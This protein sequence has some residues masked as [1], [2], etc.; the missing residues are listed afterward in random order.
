LIQTNFVSNSARKR[1][2]FFHFG[3]SSWSKHFGVEK[4]SKYP[5][6]SLGC[7][8]GP[9]ERVGFRIELMESWDQKTEVL[10]FEILT[11]GRISPR[12]ALHEA[13][14]GLV[15]KFSAIAN[16]TLPSSPTQYYIKT[17][18]FR[19]KFSS[20]SEF[21]EIYNQRI[22]GESFFHRLLNAGLSHYQ[23]PFG[24][25]LRNL[26][27][28]KER[29]REFQNLGFQTLGQLLERLTSDF[30]S[31]PYCLEKKRHQA[32]RSFGISYYSGSL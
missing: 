15:Y 7:P 6:L 19:K 13:A 30:Y 17:K 20:C 14:L 22:F 10:I 25:E 12:H 2:Q 3:E 26:D 31:F 5:W 29:Y 8:S 9:V 16:V 21:K 11:T 4:Y 18:S 27:L 28:S 24:F 1:D 23:K 32:L